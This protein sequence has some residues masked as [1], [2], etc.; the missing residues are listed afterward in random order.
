MMH[1]MGIN[2]WTSQVRAD[3]PLSF[4][5]FWWLINIQPG[6]LVFQQDNACTIKPYM[7]SRFVRQ[8]GYDKLYIGNPN[9]SF[10]FSGN[11][12]EGAR[13][14]YYSSAGGTGAI[15]S[16]PQQMP[17]SFMSPGFYTWYIIANTLPG[18]GINTSCI[19]AIKFMYNAIKGPITSQ[20]RGM[21]EYLEAEK[22]AGRYEAAQ[23]S[24]RGAETTIE[25]SARKSHQVATKSTQSFYSKGDSSCKKAQKGS[26]A[27]V[28]S[29][30]VSRLEMGLEK[31][32]SGNKDSKKEEE[33]AAPLIRS[34]HSRGPAVS[35]GT[36]V[37]KEPQLEVASTS[38]MTSEK[39]QRCDRALQAL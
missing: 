14:W 31:I 2:S 36:E 29:Q 33:L 23:E 35:V 32:L 34:Q 37:V 3:S 5:I 39:D 15:F 17:N 25:C 20:M 38:L 28:P 4:W 1:I 9:A 7:P 22:E 27:E 24:K 10:R 26:E 19:K 6:Y 12:F 21:N 16:L 8:F 13:A 18:F 30:G 11:L